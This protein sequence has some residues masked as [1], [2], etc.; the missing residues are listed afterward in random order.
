MILNEVIA[1]FL[2]MEMDLPQ[3]VS[4]DE[5][6]ELASRLISRIKADAD[7]QVI[8][9][10]LARFQLNQ[11]CKPVKPLNLRELARR[12]VVTVKAA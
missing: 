5:V 3:N 11:F 1:G 8:E 2:W 9:Y 4:R 7:E 6:E 12:A 10:D